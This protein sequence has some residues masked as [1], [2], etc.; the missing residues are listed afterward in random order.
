MP[1]RKGRPWFDISVDHIFLTQNT[2]RSNKFGGQRSKALRRFGL[3]RVGTLR[4]S[5]IYTWEDAAK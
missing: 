3:G 5:H 1:T 2:A 4:F